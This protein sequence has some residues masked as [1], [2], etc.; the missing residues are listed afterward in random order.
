LRQSNENLNKKKSIT[1]NKQT[2][3]VN[4]GIGYLSSNKTNIF[5]KKILKFLKN[6]KTSENA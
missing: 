6:P 2:V 3:T 1:G 5:H 4:T